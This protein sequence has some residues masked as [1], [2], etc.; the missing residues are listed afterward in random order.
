MFHEEV[1]EPGAGQAKREA[2]P[3]RKNAD[4]KKAT[5]EATPNPVD[6]SPESPR[7]GA[8]GTSQIFY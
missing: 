4:P 6:P 1:T 5:M 3:D 2:T 7:C 8:V